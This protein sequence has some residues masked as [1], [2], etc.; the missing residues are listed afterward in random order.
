MISRIPISFIIGI[1][2]AF[3]TVA[4]AAVVAVSIAIIV[5]VFL[6]AFTSIQRPQAR[7]KK[8]FDYHCSNFSTAASIKVGRQTLRSGKSILSPGNLKIREALEA[9]LASAD[10]E[11]EFGR[12]GP[13]NHKERYGKIR[14]LV[15]TKKIIKSAAY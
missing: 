11:S 3:V 2:S 14:V 4:A 13:R 8:N 6:S 5:V 12:I 15:P 7:L 1:V 10:I 9:G